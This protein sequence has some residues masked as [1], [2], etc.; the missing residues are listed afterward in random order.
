VV[1]TGFASVPPNPRRAVCAG[2]GRAQWPCPSL[3]PDEPTTDVLEQLTGA[4]RIAVVVGGELAG[5]LPK[6]KL[7]RRIDLGWRLGTGRGG[8]PLTRTGA[9]ETAAGDL[10][11]A[12]GCCG[13]M[14]H[15]FR[16][17]LRM[18]CS[19]ALGRAWVGVAR[20]C[21]LLLF[22]RIQGSRNDDTSNGAGPGQRP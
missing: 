8:A 1:A 10:A 11:G 13:G 15:P 22:T 2:E 21:S 5:L 16:V 12:A 18:Q 3:R 20:R 19:G 17:T 14:R 6:A 4:T 7:L 9:T